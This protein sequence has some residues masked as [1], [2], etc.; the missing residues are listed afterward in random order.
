MLDVLLVGLED[1]FRAVFAF[2]GDFDHTLSHGG[3]EDMVKRAR[4]AGV[5]V[6]MTSRVR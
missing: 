2:K 6:Y 4:D 5:P 3:T 1:E